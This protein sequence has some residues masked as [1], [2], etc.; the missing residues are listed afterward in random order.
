MSNKNKS[1]HEK[2]DLKADKKQQ[3]SDT[4]QKLPDNVNDSQ[5]D[6]SV[7]TADDSAKG[8]YSE[9]GVRKEDKP[10]SNRQSN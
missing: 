1:T 2:V 10:A 7:S 8:K 5:D 9:T 3:E 4:Y 6:Y